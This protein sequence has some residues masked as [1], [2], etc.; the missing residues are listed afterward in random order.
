VQR[1]VAGE[2][3]GV[4]L[5]AEAQLD[6]AVH[7][8][9]AAHPP[10]HAELVEELGGA[11]LEDPRTNPALHIGSGAAFEDHRVDPGAVQQPGQD[12]PGRTGPHDANLCAHSRPPD[13]C[14][15]LT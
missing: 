9:L 5:A 1:E 15:S 3:G 6:A 8:A 14:W 10:A 2:P 7:H 4:P 13:R 11:V 12:E